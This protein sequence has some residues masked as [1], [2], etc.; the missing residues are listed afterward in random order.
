MYVYGDLVQ[1][2]M[3]ITTFFNEHLV[4]RLDEYLCFCA[5][6]SDSINEQSFQTQLQRYVKKGKLSLVRKGLYVVNSELALTDTGVNP[7]MIAAKAA[8][9]SVLSYHTALE[10]HGFAYTDFNAHTFITSHRITEFSY[11]NQDYRPIHRRNF[12]RDVTIDSRVMLGVEVFATSVER[13]IVDVLDKPELSGGWEEVY[14]SLE[15][16]VAFDVSKAIEYALSLNKAS[17]IA[18][19]GYFLEHLTDYAGIDQALIRSLLPHI[20]KNHYYI[21]RKNSLGQG[22]LIKKWNIIVPNYLH[23]KQ[24][25]EPGHDLDY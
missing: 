24:W 1:L 11:N 9:D 7:F 22:T 21:D 15:S 8:D 4:F 25:E 20:P 17:I 13:T 18:K 5:K 10:F 3:S 16:V 23:E 12:K 6:G 19:L 14:R 2:V